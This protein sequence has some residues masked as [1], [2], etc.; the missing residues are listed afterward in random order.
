[1]RAGIFAIFLSLIASSASAS[2]YVAT[3]PASGGG[4]FQIN[5]TGSVRINWFFPEVTFLPWE[6]GSGSFTSSG[7][8]T[9]F[10]I[11]TETQ[12]FWNVQFKEVMYNLTTPIT[13]YHPID[14]N[15]TAG[16][17]IDLGPNDHT[18]SIQYLHAQWAEHAR[19]PFAPYM[20]LAFDGDLLTLPSTFTLVTPVPEPSTWAMMLL[21]FAGV[22]YMTYRRR[23]AAL[24]A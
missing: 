7:W 2:M 1:M 18:L 22:G 9:T 8:E 12:T 5:G 15:S 19:E 17:T 4:T 16:F 3:G 24:G 11:S 20:T 21:G 23:K 10:R 6:Y 13:V 14:A